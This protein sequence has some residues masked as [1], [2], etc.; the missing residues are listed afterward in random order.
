VE[1][2]VVPGFGIVS[3]VEHQSRIGVLTIANSQYGLFTSAP[4]EAARKFP[5]AEVVSVSAGGD[6]LL[7]TS[8]FVD[9]VLSDKVRE[10]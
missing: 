8:E 3:V 5:E 4:F 2:K 6:A 7:I 10:V 1:F 9:G